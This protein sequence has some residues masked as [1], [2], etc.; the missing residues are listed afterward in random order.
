MRRLGTILIVLLVLAAGV[1]AFVALEPSTS[2]NGA[3]GGAA[4]GGRGGASSITNQVTVSKGSVVLT[5][6]ATGSI[7]PAQQSNLTFKASGTVHDVKVQQGQ[8]VTAGQVLASVDATDQQAAVKQAQ[9]NLAA[10]QTA[11]DKVLQPVDPNT[12]TMA[13]A[14]VK[15][16]EGAYESKASAGSTP[17]DI[18]AAQAKVQQAQADKAYADQ[19]MNQAGGRYGQTDPN[20]QL[21]LAQ[22][23]QS[24]FNVILAQLNLQSIQIGVSVASAEAN[25]AYAQAK[26]A[27][28]EAGSLQSDIDQAQANIVAAQQSL[29]QANHALADTV[30]VAPYAGVITQINIKAGEPSQ[31]TAMVITDLSTL[32]ANINVD[33]TDIGGIVPG[34]KLGLT[35]DALPGV[36]LTAKVDRIYPIADSTASVIEYPVHISLD[37]TDQTLLPGMTVNATFYTQQVDNV[38]RVPN[39]YL[40]VNPTTGQTTVNLV[41]PNSVGT[42]PVPVKVGL[43][44]AD[45]TEIISGLNPGDNIALV[46]QTSTSGG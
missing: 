6:A 43:A 5:V 19:L 37:P 29:D 15:S 39:S 3:A 7:V 10:A 16:A 24:G 4:R 8:Q 36:Q 17:A 20:Y 40:K 32:Y 13:Q 2:A 25:I 18:A 9:L 35:V 34:G 41:L 26:L 12:I 33:E 14:A 11:L 21:A 42:I 28:V 31:G 38:V 45:Y 23:G 27:Q 46:A 1:S 22:D 30:L 44:G